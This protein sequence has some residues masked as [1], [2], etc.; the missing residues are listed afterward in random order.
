MAFLLAAYKFAAGFENLR[1]VLQGPKTPSI[2]T[3]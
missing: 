3:A 2:F 1:G